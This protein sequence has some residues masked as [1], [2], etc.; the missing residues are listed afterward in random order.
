MRERNH[1][2]HN[3]S[4]KEE[5]EGSGVSDPYKL[6][7]NDLMTYIV[8]NIVILTGSNYFGDK[9]EGTSVSEYLGCG[10]AVELCWFN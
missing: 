9:T 6:S 4:I 3:T 1:L 2:C 7:F 10:H 8:V 5:E